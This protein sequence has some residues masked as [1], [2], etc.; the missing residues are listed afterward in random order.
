MVGYVKTRKSAI[1]IQVP[2]GDFAPHHKTAKIASS[3]HKSA[4]VASCV[5]KAKTMLM[6]THTSATMFP[7]PMVM[8]SPL[9]WQSAW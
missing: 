2:H 6:M 7:T 9:S 8:S 1:L 3:T 5:N 4:L